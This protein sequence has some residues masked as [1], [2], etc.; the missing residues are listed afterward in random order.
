MNFNTRQRP[1]S[2]WPNT[3][4]QLGNPKCTGTE[5]CSYEPRQDPT[6]RKES[7]CDRAWKKYAQ[8]V[9]DAFREANP[10]LLYQLNPRC[11]GMAAP[12]R[13]RCAKECTG[14][15]QRV[16]DHAELARFPDGARVII[17]HPYD[18]DEAAREKETRDAQDTLPGA[19]IRCGGKER[20]W[21]FPQHSSLTVIGQ[22]EAVDRVNLDY[23]LPNGMEPA[24]C[25]RW[26]GE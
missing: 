6:S 9:F 1:T 4:A 16:M 3:S 18:M 23:Q 21:Y 13:H 22:P 10:S 8:A 11:I 17:T 25:A 7:G 20:S 2:A 12:G 15:N 19:V 24:G 26:E 14:T 5:R